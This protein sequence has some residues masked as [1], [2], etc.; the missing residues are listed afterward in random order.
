MVPV[1]RLARWAAASMPRAS[2]DTVPKPAAPRSR[3]SRSPGRAPAPGQFC[4]RPPRRCASR[5]WRPAAASARRACRAPRARAAR[6][7][8]SA[9]A[10]DKRHIGTDHDDTVFSLY[11]DVFEG[12]FAGIWITAEHRLP[13]ELALLAPQL[14]PP[15]HDDSVARLGLPP[16][17][18]ERP[19]VQVPAR[20]LLPAS[21]R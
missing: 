17:S 3:A 4:P 13:T 18:P 8:S 12:I 20:P 7:R 11:F 5:R 9:S 2:P 15:D 6:R 14:I 1:A 19:L 10:A 16:T 21:G